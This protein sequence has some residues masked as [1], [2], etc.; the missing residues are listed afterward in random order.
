M[1]FLPLLYGS[2]RFT[3]YHVL[4]GP[5]LARLLTDNMNEYPAVWCLLAI[6]MLLLVVKTPLRR[7]LFVRNWLLWPRAMRQPRCAGAS[8]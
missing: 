8:A 2:W 1:F 4:V 7:V 6:G 3:L 5:T